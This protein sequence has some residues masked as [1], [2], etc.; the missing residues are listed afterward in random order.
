MTYTFLYLT[1]LVLSAYL[2]QHAVLVG[3]FE[4]SSVQFLS[5]AEDAMLMMFSAPSAYIF[6][7]RVSAKNLSLHTK[8]VGNECFEGF[9]IPS[10]PSQ[11]LTC[12]PS[13]SICTFFLIRHSVLSLLYHIQYM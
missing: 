9:D 3:C 12:C 2:C 8:Y 11:Y 10:Y 13:L 4:M 1:S 5:A 6:L 7:E